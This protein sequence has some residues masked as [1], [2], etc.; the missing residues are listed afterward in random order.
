MSIYIKNATYLCLNSSK[1]VSYYSYYFRL[2]S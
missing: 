1:G 2:W